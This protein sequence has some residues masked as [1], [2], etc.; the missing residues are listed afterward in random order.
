[1]AAIDTLEPF[2]R[3]FDR[4]IFDGSF[5]VQSVKAI[6]DGSHLSLGLEQSG[7]TMKAVWFSAI[8]PGERIPVT[9]GDTI[10]VLYEIRANRYNGATSL[11]L[12]I[13]HV[14]LSALAAAA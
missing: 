10:T 6:G 2:G 4:P 12:L 7:L 13:R 8:A 11:Q 3:Q 14:R 1:L 9:K 5:I